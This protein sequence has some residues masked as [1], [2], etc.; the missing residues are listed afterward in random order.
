ML[1]V[2]PVWQARPG[3][4]CTTGELRPGAALAKN[5]EEGGV[6]TV[7]LQQNITPPARPRLAPNLNL[8]EGGGWAG[9]VEHCTA[10]T[11][12]ATLQCCSVVTAAGETSSRQWTADLLLGLVDCRPAAGAGGA[13][14]PPRCRRAP[15]PPPLLPAASIAA[16]EIT[17]LSSVWPAT[18]PDTSLLIWVCFSQ[19]QRQIFCFIVSVEVKMCKWFDVHLF[20]HFCPFHYFMFICP[21]CAQYCEVARNRN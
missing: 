18:Q 14:M 19:W 15:P 7:E 16:G 1:G 8:T 20:D 9:P 12:V 4:P 11:A 3:K 6:E 2:S 10:V 5:A 21:L 13:L 17:I